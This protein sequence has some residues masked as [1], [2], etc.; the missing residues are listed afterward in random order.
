MLDSDDCGRV[1]EVDR[2]V[3]L[4]G[5]VLFSFD[6]IEVFCDKSFGRFDRG[7]AAPTVLLLTTRCVWFPSDIT[8]PID[9]GFRA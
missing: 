9:C 3:R 4:L 7:E 6:P 2:V 5:V 1:T 8:S